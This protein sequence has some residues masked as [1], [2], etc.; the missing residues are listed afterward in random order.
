ME[1]FDVRCLIQNIITFGPGIQFMWKKVQKK[2]LV[3]SFHLHI[4]AGT[5]KTKMH[6]KL[7]ICLCK[8]KKILPFAKQPFVSEV[9][10]IRP[11]MPN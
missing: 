8:H 3:V 11:E 4:L 7:P 9:H 2:G 6:L 10:R 1:S 5:Y